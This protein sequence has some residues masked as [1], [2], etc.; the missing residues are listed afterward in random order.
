MNLNQNNTKIQ[1]NTVVLN[2]VGWLHVPAI[3]CFLAL[4]V[5]EELGG[6]SSYPIS[7]DPDFKLQAESELPA[8][9]GVRHVEH[10]GE[11]VDIDDMSDVEEE[12]T[13]Q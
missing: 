8:P 6:D 12:D 11:A 13:Y 5:F 4:I 10:S 3:A 2:L 1:S 9:D 7:T